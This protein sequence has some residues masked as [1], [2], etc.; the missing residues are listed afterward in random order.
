MI[1]RKLLILWLAQ[2]ISLLGD[3]IYLLAL[4]LYVYEM[5]RSASTMSMVS[6]F[7]TMPYILFSVIGGALADRHHKRRILT[8]GNMAAALP[9]LLFV[10]LAYM[11]WLKLWHVC[12]C[13]FVLAVIVSVVNPTFE[14][15]LPT[16][17]QRDQ[18]LRANALMELLTPLT[19]IAGPALAGLL[20]SL[21]GVSSTLLL[22]AAS[23]VG[24]AGLLALIRVSPAE[25]SPTGEG[26]VSVLRDVLRGF[27]FISSARTLRWGVFMSTS[28][29]LVLGSYQVTLIFHMRSGLALR[30]AEVGLVMTVTSV[31]TLL[32]SLVLVPRIVT[33]HKS[34]LMMLALLAQGIAVATIGSVRNLVA[35]AALQSLYA[36]TLALYVINWRAL[37]QEITPPGLRG[38]VAGACRGIAYAGASIGA[39]IGA[40]LL[41]RINVPDLFLLDGALVGLIALV[42]GLG[43]RRGERVAG[44][45]AEA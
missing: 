34:R 33:A 11:H 9:L 23:F 31:V 21:S 20:I 8:L 10:L 7:E 16:L 38:K 37:R 19:A 43:L 44:A 32:F 22:N 42:A 15:T 1:N 18:L 41:S 17:V 6:A 12:A 28:S 3:Q 2:L 14:A 5:T 30:P 29:N 39:I 25:E 36:A 45:P 40:A 26:V 24:A 27:I 4:P 13:V 35:V